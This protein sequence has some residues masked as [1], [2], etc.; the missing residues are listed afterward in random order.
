MIDVLAHDLRILN[1][2]YLIKEAILDMQTLKS[3]NNNPSHI[4]HALGNLHPVIQVRGE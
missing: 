3:K 4:V 1:H 2:S